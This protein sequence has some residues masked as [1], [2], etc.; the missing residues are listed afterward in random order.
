MGP[1]VIGKTLLR[2]FID[3][4]SSP[5]PRTTARSVDT[6]EG[7]IF[8]ST[9]IRLDARHI[10]YNAH[11]FD[12][13]AY[14]CD[15][16]EQDENVLARA[17]LLVLNERAPFLTRTLLVLNIDEAALDLI[18]GIEGVTEVDF[19]HLCFLSESLRGMNLDSKGLLISLGT[20]SLHQRVSLAAELS[21]LH[22]NYVETAK[23]IVLDDHATSIANGLLAGQTIL[24][25]ATI[26]YNETLHIAVDYE[27]RL[28][29]IVDETEINELHE[30]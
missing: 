8:A 19:V 10:V 2:R 24:L 28:L 15:H 26:G 18:D 25:D 12:A 11:L 16:F 17:A 29:T 23:S 21:K 1:F 3:D 9:A 4:S 7:A 27:D 14:F 30:D 22:A 13:A 5:E 20:T 6:N